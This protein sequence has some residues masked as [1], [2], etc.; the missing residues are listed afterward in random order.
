MIQAEAVYDVMIIG[1]GPSGISASLYTLRAGLTTLVVS[2]G[3]ESL[4]MAE[5][6]GNYYGVPGDST[7]ADLLEAGVAQAKTLGAVMV[8]D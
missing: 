6:I 2:K 3:G 8:E 4:G 1:K 5:R 7:G